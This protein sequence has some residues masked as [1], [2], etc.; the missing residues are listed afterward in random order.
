METLSGEQLLQEKICKFFPLR[1]DPILDTNL[2]S[3]DINSELQKLLPFGKHPPFIN[4]VELKW[5][6]HLGYHENMFETR[7]VRAN[8]Y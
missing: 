2:R 3:F 7:G 5:L 4:T 6:E 1:V 8:E